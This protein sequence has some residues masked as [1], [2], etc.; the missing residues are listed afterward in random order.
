ME[1]LAKLIHYHYQ[2]QN[3]KMEQ[4]KKILILQNI[5]QLQK[6]ENFIRLKIIILLVNYIQLLMEKIIGEMDMH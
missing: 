5:A 2:K 6:Q 3:R 1:F 4:M